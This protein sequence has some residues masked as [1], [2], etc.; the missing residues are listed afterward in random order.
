MNLRDRV[1]AIEDLSLREK[2]LI[3]ATVCALIISLAQFFLV[4]PRL[5]KREVLTAQHNN[6]LATN[7]RLQL[8]LDGKLLMPRY[9]RQK[10]LEKEISALEIQ[11]EREAG[12]IREETVAMVAADQM[13]DLLQELLSEQDVELAGLKNIPPKH[14]L[15]E[16]VNNPGGQTI[17]LYQHGIELE[18]KGNYHALRRYLLA[19]EGQPWQLIW[20]SVHFEFVSG[21]NSLMKLKVKTLSTDDVWL[22]V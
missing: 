3:T 22:G 12:L 13:P 20:D 14:L 9:T 15:E 6:L 7:G 1:Q 16:D 4:D 18:L 5:Q 11:L 19:V 8:Q 17:Q 2:A 21:G 10:V